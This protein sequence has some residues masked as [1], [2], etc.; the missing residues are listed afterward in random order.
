MIFKGRRGTFLPLLMLLFVLPSCENSEK[1]VRESL[2]VLDAAP[3]G[4]EKALD[5][6]YQEARTKAI[7][8]KDDSLRTSLLEDLEARY[9]TRKEPFEAA[10]R[11]AAE[12]ERRRKEVEQAQRLAEIELDRKRKEI[13]LAAEAASQ[14]QAAALALAVAAAQSQA[15]N[16]LQ[17][18]IDLDLKT[19]ASLMDDNTQVLVIRNANAYSVDFDLKCYTRSGSSKTLF[20]S[21]PAR[22]EK[23]IGFLEGW[24]GNF[25]SGERCEAYYDGQFVWSVRIP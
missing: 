13:E 12:E 11:E 16:R 23:E 20:V 3:A 8:I 18:V 5:S 7:L 14:E 19:R 10:R 22:G 21:V 2:A 4:D 6:A 24:E 25:V 15:N 17:G 1:K 9:Q